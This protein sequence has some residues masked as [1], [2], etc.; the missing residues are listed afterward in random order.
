VIVRVY[1]PDCTD[2]TAPDG[3]GCVMCS[4]MGHIAIDRLENG[5]IPQGYTEWKDRELGPIS[6]NPLT[7]R[8]DARQA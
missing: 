6:L 7:L 2:G 5:D 8:T 4:A 3:L 1:C